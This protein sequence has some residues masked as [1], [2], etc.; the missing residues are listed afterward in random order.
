M[1]FSLT[2][3]QEQ[4]R[5][6]IQTFLE[7]ELGRQH[8]QAK[9]NYFIEESSKKFSRK[10]AKKGWIGL[11]WPQEYG[12]AGRSYV[13]RTIFMEELLRNQAPLMYHFFGERQIGPSLM[14]F[15]S[16]EQKQEFLPKIINSDIS[17]CLGMSEPDAG[18]DVAAVNTT[19]KEDGDHYIINGQKTWTSHAHK[20]D[21]IWLLTV[22]DPDAP[23]HR[24]LSEFIVDMKSP[25]VTVRPLLNMI[26]AHSFNE[27]FFDDVKVHKRYL[28]GEKNRGFQQMLAQV[29]F[30]RAG[31]ER[32]MQNYP[33]FANLKTYIKES[34]NPS[35]SL[36]RDKI[37][38]LEIEFQVGKLLIY[39]VAWTIDRGKIPNYEAAVSKA[40]CTRFEQKLG[41]M[42]TEILGPFGHVMSGFENIPLGGDAAESYL[43]SPS[44]TIQ[45]GTLEILKIVI[46]TR[47]LGIQFKGK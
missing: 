3:E 18:S 4:F 16:E 30:E 38:Q 9:S 7:E 21:Y 12:G 29:D 24:N 39:Q 13:D 34:A 26:G 41:D 45:G 20:A 5:K 22:T 23:K 31:I 44:Y 43:W 14:H 36:I 47:G 15:G 32:L 27:V 10:L 28:V 40:F 11:T 2:K 25:G 42:A 8:L 37:A 6:E 35:D 1:E 33:L 19:A 46:A 17:F